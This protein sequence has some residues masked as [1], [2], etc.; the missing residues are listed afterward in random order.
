MKFHLPAVLSRLVLALFSA[1]LLIGVPQYRQA[2]AQNSGQISFQQR[3]AAYRANNLGVAQLEQFN[4][5]EAAREFQRALSI[6]T[7]LH[8]ARI[9]L[10]AA[11]G[12][13]VIGLNVDTEKGADVKGFLARKQ[14]SY[15]IVIGGIPAIEQIYE[16]EELSVPLTVRIDEKGIVTDLIPGWSAKTQ[17]K[18]E[19]MAGKR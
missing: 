17:R 14:V 2:S 19:R 9:N 4:Y 13:D 12:I 18:F 6:H 8:I 10:L 16:T 7:Q 15:P 1:G 11:R 3:E 5:K